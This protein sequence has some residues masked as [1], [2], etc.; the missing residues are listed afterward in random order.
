MRFRYVFI[1]GGSLAVI[2]ALLFTDPDAGV[3]TGMALLSLS[4]G[5]LAVAL[6]HISRLGM[7]DYVD[8]R[9]LAEQANEKG[10]VFLGVCIVLGCA[11][12]MFGNLLRS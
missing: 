8:M 11:L 10:L 5:V 2:A 1:V 9:K 3:S 6:A 4:V 12:L 7:F